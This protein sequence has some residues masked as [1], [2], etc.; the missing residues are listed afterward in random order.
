MQALLVATVFGVAL[1]ASHRHG[2]PA[3]LPGAALGWAL[4]L[5]VER[6]AA[7]L[8][9]GG[10][11]LLVGWRATRGE[12]PIKFGHIEYA[13]MAAEASAELTAAHERRIRAL[14]LINNVRP[15]SET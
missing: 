5:H 15:P 2:V 1:L 8:A 10:V 11:V 9:A 13:Q 14:E 3:D 6:A 12:F 4:L 7:V